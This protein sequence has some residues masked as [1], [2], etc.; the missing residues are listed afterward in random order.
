MLERLL[1]VQ[2][3]HPPRGYQGLLD[4]L[5]VVPLDGAVAV[6]PCPFPGLGSD[7]L[8]EVGH[9]SPIDIFHD[10]HRDRQEASD[11][12]AVATLPIPREGGDVLGPVL[13]V[14]QPPVVLD[15]R[16]RFFVV[17]VTNYVCRVTM[18][19]VIFLPL[20]ASHNG[21]MRVRGYFKVIRP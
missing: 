20:W 9:S 11:D 1:G 17:I 8:E 18:F 5:V 16:L 7:P 6:F 10:S 4:A 2:T 12:L 19:M 15:D 13:E 3:Q 14:H 21:N